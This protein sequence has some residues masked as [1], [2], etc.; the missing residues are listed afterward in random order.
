MRPLFTALVWLVAAV[1][2]AFL[3]YLPVGGFLA[4]RWRR[5]IWA[6]M[7]AVVWGAGSVFLHWGCPL[8][9]LERWARSRAGMPPLDPGGF[10]DHYLTGVVYPTAASVPVQVVVFLAVVLS[11]AGYALTARRA[12]TSRVTG[13]VSL[14]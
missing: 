5:G 8:T 14:G 10:I 13:A 1:H 4:L 12:R 3:V 9:E 7:A 2:F 11:W 6:H